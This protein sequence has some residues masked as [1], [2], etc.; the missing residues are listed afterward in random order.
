MC[1][2]TG[3]SCFQLAAAVVVTFLFGLS[4]GMALG[5]V[6]GGDSRQD[7]HD[8]EMRKYNETKGGKG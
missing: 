7:F 6:W 1:I 5:W 8:D 4:V 2:L 3:G